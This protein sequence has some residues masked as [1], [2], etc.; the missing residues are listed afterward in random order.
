M[1]T[2]DK[3]FKGTNTPRPPQRRRSSPFVLQC[4]RATCRILAVAGLLWLPS[5]FGFVDAGTGGGRRDP[6]HERNFAHRRVPL[7]IYIESMCPDARDCLQKLVVPAYWQVM[8][9]VNLGINYVGEYDDLPV[10]N[11]YIS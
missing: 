9:K 1:E 2:T 4:R 7:D 3:S 10:S 8:D 6:M 5:I 11:L